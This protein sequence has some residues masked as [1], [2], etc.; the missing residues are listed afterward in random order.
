MYPDQGS[1]HAREGEAAHWVAS[2]LLRTRINIPPIAPNGEQITTEMLQGGEMYVQAIHEVMGSELL[3]LHIEER[4]TIASIHRDCW[5]TPDAWWFDMSSSTLHI[6]DY[7]FGHGFVEVFEN[8]QLIE[9]ASGILDQLGIDGLYDQ[10][11]TVNFYIVQ[12][13]SYHRDGAVRRW[14]VRASDLRPFFNILHVAEAR[15]FDA[16][17]ICR[18][19]PEC[20]YCT[21]RH[22]CEALQRS[23]LSAVD[24]SQC[25]IVHDLNAL[26]TGSELR[27]LEHAAM[28]LDARITGLR[29]QALAMIARGEVVSWYT[30]EPTTGRQR[31]IKPDGE[32]VAMGVLMGF[33]LSQPAKPITPKQAIS[34]GMNKMLVESLSETQHGA[35]KLVADN[36]SKA[37]KIFGGVS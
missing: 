3:A 19:S 21:A 1:P 23:A 30:A 5:G 29:E 15:T 4:V 12:P 10:R 17:P 14:S 11:T 24:L 25:A 28:L 35:L 18:P 6:W 26:A 20:T 2:E 37:R 27:V 31:W 9:Y 8:W 7:K 36:G 32:V 22:A 16:A 13:R 34:A 33:D